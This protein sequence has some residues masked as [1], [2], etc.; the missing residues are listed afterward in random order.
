MGID[1]GILAKIRRSGYAGSAAKDTQ[2]QEDEKS[3]GYSSED[4]RRTAYENLSEDKL[5]AHAD[6]SHQEHKS[7]TGQA[8]KDNK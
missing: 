8:P 5:H 6:A 4:V 3:S 1:D 2:R 7:R